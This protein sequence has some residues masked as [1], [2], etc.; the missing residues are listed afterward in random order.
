[1]KKIIL[2]LAISL[3]YPACSQL[4]NTP[5]KVDQ[6]RAIG[7][8][9]DSA[10]Y[11][12][13]TEETPVIAGL[14]FYLA[15]DR[16]TDLDY[17]QIQVEG[18]QLQLVDLQVDFEDYSRL[19]IFQVRATARLPLASELRFSDNDDTTSVAYALLFRQ[20]GQ[21]ERFRG[22]IKI[23]RPDS[24]KLQQVKPNI[25]IVS[26]S[27]GSRV[28]AAPLTLKAELSNTSDE[29]YRISWLVAE[30]VIEKHR[31]I[32]TKW[33]EFGASPQ[34]I[35]VTMRGLDSWNFDF[36]VIELGEP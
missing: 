2:L 35:I 23:Y 21:E 9:T 16:K 8:A 17:T 36:D 27:N 20:D 4:D 15:S 33:K 7:L 18:E 3:I 34:T 26:P 31:A 30:G 14:T 22:R 12:Y 25:S 29:P 1:M 19:R 11:T 10:A 6:L 24:P 5:E 32:E 13:S 28:P